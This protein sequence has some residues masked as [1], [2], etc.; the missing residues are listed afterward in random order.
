MKDLD[1]ADNVVLKINKK[2]EQ[3]PVKMLNSGLSGALTSPNATPHLQSGHS[4]LTGMCR[5]ATSCGNAE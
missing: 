3:N 5:S 1:R 4:E 2:D